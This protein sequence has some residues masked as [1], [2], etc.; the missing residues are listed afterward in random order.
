MIH[1]TTGQAHSRMGTGQI[2]SAEGKSA[3]MLDLPA[4]ASSGAGGRTGWARGH[5]RTC[6]LIR[7][8][9][10][11]RGTVA[12]STRP[13]RGGATSCDDGKS[14]PRIWTRT[15]HMGS[16]ICGY[17]VRTHVNVVGTR[18]G[19]PVVVSRLPA[20]PTAPRAGSRGRLVRACR[21]PRRARR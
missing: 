12:V 17:L 14:P 6:F 8:S 1:Y 16:W 19:E 2:E 5:A 21:D 18:S 13:A 4:K 15:R 11:A 10:G 9:R 3:I 7:G 20:R